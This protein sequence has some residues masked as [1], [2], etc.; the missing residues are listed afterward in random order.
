MFGDL[1]KQRYI[2]N[3]M[4]PEDCFQFATH[5]MGNKNQT[6]EVLCPNTTQVIQS[7]VF[8]SRFC[9]LKEKNVEIFYLVCVFCLSN[10]Q[11]IFRIVF[12]LSLSCIQSLLCLPH[13][14]TIPHR[15]IC[16]HSRTKSIQRRQVGIFF[17]ICYVD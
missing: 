4:F 2:H 8:I 5:K 11:V 3:K 16:Q 15:Q 1:D 7:N 9:L 12:S 17:S 6:I 13:I 14:C 10:S